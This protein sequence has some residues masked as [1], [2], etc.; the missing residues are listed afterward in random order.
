MQESAP[1]MTL[2]LKTFL[3]IHFSWYDYLKIYI[4]DGSLKIYILDGSLKIFSAPDN[5]NFTSS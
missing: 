4:L 1:C 3:F 2:G 5:D